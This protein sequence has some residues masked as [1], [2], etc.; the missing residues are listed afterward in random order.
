MFSDIH[1]ETHCILPQSF[2]FDDVH[3]DLGYTD[4]C[5]QY[6]FFKLKT[7]RQTAAMETY[8]GKVYFQ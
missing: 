3:V 1:E 2:L 7:L 8:A 5:D 4:K 6:P